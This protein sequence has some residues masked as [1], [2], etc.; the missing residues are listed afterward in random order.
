MKNKLVVQPKLVEEDELPKCS[1]G[2]SLD[3]VK[4]LD[5][6]DIRVIFHASKGCVVGVMQAPF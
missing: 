5:Y 1:C 6:G 4:Y 3:Q 2:E